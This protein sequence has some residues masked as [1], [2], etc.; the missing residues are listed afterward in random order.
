[1]FHKY[2]VVHISGGTTEEGGIFKK[3]LCV[4]VYCIYPIKQQ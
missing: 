3:R 1:M 4:V 2:G